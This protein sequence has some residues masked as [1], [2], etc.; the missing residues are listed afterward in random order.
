MPFSGEAYAELVAT[1]FPVVEAAALCAARPYG[2][3]VV[4]PLFIWMGLQGAAR[5][6]LALA[7]GAPMIVGVYAVMSAP[8]AEFPAETLIVLIAKEFM[9]G[10]F[11]GAPSASAKTV[12]AAPCNPIQIN[13]GNTTKKP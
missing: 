9:I 6:V 8:S 4:F 1:V 5:T 12:R 13:S 7:L 2:F 10:A 11:L 3:L